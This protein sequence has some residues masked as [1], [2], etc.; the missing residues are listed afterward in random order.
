MYATAEGGSLVYQAQLPGTN[1]SDGNLDADEFLLYQLNLN[2]AAD[3]NGDFQ[4]DGLDYGIWA[5]AFGLGS[6][7]DTD[8]DL[9]SDGFDFLTWQLQFASPSGQ[10]NSQT[11]SVPEPSALVLALGAII[12]CS[13]RRA[14]GR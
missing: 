9:D 10:S 8:D 5:S 2:Q 3:F 7:G 13:F 6:G 1:D 11:T 14:T 12:V 4:V